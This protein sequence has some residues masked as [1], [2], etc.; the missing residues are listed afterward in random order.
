MLLGAM[1]MFFVPGAA[2]DVVGE[3]CGEFSADTVQKISNQEPVQGKLY[4][5]KG[6]VRMETGTGGTRGIIIL[7]ATDK[8]TLRLNPVRKEYIE[9]PWPAEKSNRPRLS[10]RQPLPGDPHHPCANPMQLKCKMLGKDEKIHDRK[11]EKWQIVRVIQADNR[12][13]KTMRFL[14]WGDRELGVNVREERFIDN[15]LKGFSELRAIEEGPQPETLFQ[16]PTDYLR[17][18]MPK[19]SSGGPPGDG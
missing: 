10:A 11:T 19:H 15:D 14:A 13:P 1:L 12:N 5:S 8:K 16:V 18:E 4:V 6:K 17:V 9:V 7:N 2:G 3:D